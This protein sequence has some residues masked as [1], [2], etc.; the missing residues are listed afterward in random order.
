MCRVLRL[1]NKNVRNSPCVERHKPSKQ[2]TRVDVA[3][4][5]RRTQQRALIE[6]K[7][8]RSTDH[9]DSQHRHS[10]VNTMEPLLMKPCELSKR[11]VRYGANSTWHSIFVP[12]KQSFNK[13]KQSEQTTSLN[14]RSLSSS[15]STTTARTALGDARDWRSARRRSPR[16]AAR[17]QT[18][19]MTY[20]GSPETT[21][22]QLSDKNFANKTM[23]LRAAWLRWCAN[24]GLYGMLVST[25]A[26]FRFEERER[27]REKQTNHVP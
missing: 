13:R 7:C 5:R 1:R 2:R 14:R 21:H 10:N 12:R 15:S 3:V 23:N 9:R 17:S 6:R 26:T 11:V 27:E 8:L 25:V 4:W 24:G 19:P 22:W 16:A 20:G 18:T